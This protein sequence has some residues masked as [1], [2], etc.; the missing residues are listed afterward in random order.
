MIALLG[1]PPKKCY[2]ERTKKYILI[3]TL[4]TVCM[5]LWAPI[6]FLITLTP[7][8]I[9]VLPVGEFRFPEL[10]P[11]EDFT[12]SNL[13]PVLQREDKRLF[14]EFAQKMLRW[15]PEERATAKILCNDPWLSHK[16]DTN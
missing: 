8:L 1:P 9:M 6:K 4:R 10:I 16:P 7:S 14:I 13:T 11:S 2:V 5:T 12:V 15:F 3:Y